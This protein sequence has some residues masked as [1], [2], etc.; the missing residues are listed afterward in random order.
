MGPTSADGKQRD[1]ANDVVSEI[2]RVVRDN[3]LQLI[4]VDPSRGLLPSS[5]A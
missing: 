2:A 3:Y 5:G 4:A 1:E